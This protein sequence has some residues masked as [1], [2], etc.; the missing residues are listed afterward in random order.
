MKMHDFFQYFLVARI[1]ENVS[2]GAAKDDIPDASAQPDIHIEN[3]ISIS[4]QRSY[5][6]Q[7]FWEVIFSCVPMY[8][9]C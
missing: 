6:R 8:E 5:F 4:V 3:G 9:T 1:D 2:P 7:Q